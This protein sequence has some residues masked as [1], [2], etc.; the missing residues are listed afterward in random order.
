MKV[1]LLAAVALAVA[2]TAMLLVGGCA[3]ARSSAATVPPAPTEVPTDVPGGTPA[4]AD[5][6]L[7]G[8]QL[9]H[10]SPDRATA[11]QISV[12]LYVSGE[13]IRGEPYVFLTHPSQGE[14]EAMD[15]KVYP[16]GSKARCVFDI[17]GAEPGVWSVQVINPDGTHHALFEAFQIVAPTPTATSTPSPTATATSTSTP[18]TTPT[19]VVVPATP[20]PSPTAMATA[21]APHGGSGKRQATRI[22]TL[23]PPTS[24]P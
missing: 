10:V 9:T 2:A 16:G 18:T 4:A 11:G 3:R 12:T 15:V 5:T 8:P 21:T 6:P 23:A 24:Q 7:P 13:H 20:T 22:P 1:D 19:L 17:G 14:I